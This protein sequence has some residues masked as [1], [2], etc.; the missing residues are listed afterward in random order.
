[1][2]SAERIKTTIF[3]K[4]YRITLHLFIYIFLIL[5]SFGL[6]ELGYL[7]EIPLL[8]II[9][10]PFFLLEKIAFTIQDPF[11]NRPSDIPMTAITKTISINIKELINEPIVSENNNVDQFYIL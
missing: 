5:L 3:P 9:S 11:E 8:I 10:I 1:M 4:T 2:G 6:I 7:I